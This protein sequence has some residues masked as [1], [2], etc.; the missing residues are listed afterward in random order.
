M[1]QH[2]WLRSVSGRLNEKKR[3]QHLKKVW[4]RD[5]EKQKLQREIDKLLDKRRKS[6]IDSLTKEDH[7]LLKKISSKIEELENKE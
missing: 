3:R 1:K 6:G 4:D 5:Q 2:D 7:E